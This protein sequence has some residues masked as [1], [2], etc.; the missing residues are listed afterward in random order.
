MSLFSYLMKLVP[1]IFV[2]LP[3]GQSFVA[4]YLT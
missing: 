1:P 2:A 4:S 3:S